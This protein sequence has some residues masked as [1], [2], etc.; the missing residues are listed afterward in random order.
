[1]ASIK[2]SVLIFEMRKKYLLYKILTKE[3]KSQLRS[4]IWKNFGARYVNEQNEKSFE[5]YKSE[6]QSTPL[7]VD[8]SGNI[9]SN[10]SSNF[11]LTD[12]LIYEYFSALV[13][14]YEI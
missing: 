7:V 11:N 13:A 4:E 12:D 14:S 10:N 6:Q 1:M 3:L 8:E 5:F 2:S 9:N